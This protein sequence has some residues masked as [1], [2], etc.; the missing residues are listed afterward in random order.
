MRVESLPETLARSTNYNSDYTRTP[1]RSHVTHRPVI[2]LPA[3]AHAHR[4]H[5]AIPRR[6]SCSYDA[7]YAARVAQLWISPPPPYIFLSYNSLDTQPS[8]SKRNRACWCIIL[9]LCTFIF[10]SVAQFGERYIY[11][12]R[13]YHKEKK[14][15]FYFFDA[16]FMH[17]FTRQTRTDDKEKR[18]SVSCMF[19]QIQNKSRFMVKLP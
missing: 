4:I 2:A 14:Y 17:R 15:C 10:P 11:D 9:S 12:I 7:S 18:V 1:T 6:Q 8:Q 5:S 3:V 19:H 13:V 16:L